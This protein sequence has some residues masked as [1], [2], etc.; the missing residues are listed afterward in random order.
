MIILKNSKYKQKKLLSIPIL[1]PKIFST[2]NFFSVHL[3]FSMYIVAVQSPS[4]VR[5]FATPLTV[6]RQASRPSLSPCVYIQHKFN[7]IESHLAYYSN[8]CILNLIICRLALFFLEKQIRY[9][10]GLGINLGSVF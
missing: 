8:I 9:N 10:I 4:Y 2:G 7:L 3:E 5:L 1:G 6:A